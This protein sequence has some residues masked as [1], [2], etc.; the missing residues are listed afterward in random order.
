[1]GYEMYFEFD[2]VGTDG[3]HVHL[4]VGAEPK[5][6]PS[7]VVQTIKSTARQ[8]FKT[9]LSNQKTFLGW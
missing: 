9:I 4:F 1:M 3:D 6:S 5:F 8:I 7:K 2:A